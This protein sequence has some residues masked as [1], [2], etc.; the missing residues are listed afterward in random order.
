MAARRAGV[1]ALAAALVTVSAQA[2][3]EGP[4]LTA[5]PTISGTLE[6]GSRLT[7]GSGTWTSATTATF[8]YQ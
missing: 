6:A 2:R 8:A 1:V 5:Q 3:S 7:A 4:V